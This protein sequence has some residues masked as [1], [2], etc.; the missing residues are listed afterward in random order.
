MANGVLTS[1]YFQTEQTV[2][3]YLLT[4]QSSYVNSKGITCL[5]YFQG[6]YVSLA[7]ALDYMNPTTSSGSTSQ[8]LSYRLFASSLLNAEK[9]STL[10]KMELTIPPNSQ[11]AV[12][13][14]R[15]MR[16][17]LS[18][19][20]TSPPV[21]GFPVEMHLFGGYT[22]NYDVQ[23]ALYDLVPMMI[24][25][26]V[27]VVLVIIGASFGSVLL[28]LR[29]ALT[30]FC[31]L[32]WT[33]GLMVLVY[34]PGKSQDDFAVLTPSILSSSGLYWIVPIMSFSILVGLALD[35]DIFLMSRVC[36]FRRL[37]W[38]DRASVCLAVEKTAG[39]ITAAG[40]IMSISFAGL[41]LPKTIVLNQYG[42]GLFVGVALD[43]F[44]VR[45][46]L[47]PSV[48]T[49]LGGLGENGRDGRLNWWPSV[50]PPVVYATDDEEE[51][52]LMRGLWVP[53]VKAEDKDKLEA[54]GSCVREVPTQDN[55]VPL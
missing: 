32:C 51:E 52:A 19:W 28:S 47:V 8:G 36:E 40:T 2:V 27:I 44:V 1:S 39:I 53:E 49:V 30:I 5:S 45:T 33:Y 20:S 11:A 46:F 23:S 22:T 17:A 42:F 26:T 15:S 9:S 18:S 34:Q 37:G 21:S 55:P 48:F 50:M 54:G 4:E 31:T 16:T 35:Y 3:N 41:L 38:S 10:M 24:S 29:L 6:Q 14:I 12:P 7:Q 13:Y 43:T 25:V